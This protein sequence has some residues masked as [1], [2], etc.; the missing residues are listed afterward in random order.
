MSEKDFTHW[1]TEKTEV[2]IHKARPFFHERDVWFCTVGANIGFE[3]DDRGD[4]FLRPVVIIKKFNK[5]VL[6]AVPLTTKEKM[7]KYYFSFKLEE[8]TTSTAILSQ[9]RLID[10]KRLQY[11]IGNIGTGDFTELKTKI[12]QLLA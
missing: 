12:T 8:A 2:Q 1:H 6:W 4:K 11:K 10:S 9:L 5:E 3:Q 7:G